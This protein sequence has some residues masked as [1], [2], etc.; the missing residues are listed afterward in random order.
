MSLRD[1]VEQPPDADL[2]RE[3]TGLVA[4][5]LMELE[6]GSMTGAAHGEKDSARRVQRNGHCDRDRE[7]RAGTVDPRI[8]RLRQGS[9][10]S[11]VPE[12]RRRP[13]KALTAVIREVY[14]QGIPTRPADDPVTAMDEICAKVGDA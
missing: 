8:P 7:P 5:R 1:L 3:M 9:D 10:V 6:V 12:P 14:V 13:Q 2:P 4:G 11:G